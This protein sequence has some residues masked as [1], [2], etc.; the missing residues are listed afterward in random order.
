MSLFDFIQQNDGIR[1][2]S[3]SY[4]HLDVYKRQEINLAFNRINIKIPTTTNTKAILNVCLL[5]TS[6]NGRSQYCLSG[7]RLIF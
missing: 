7:F 2:T 6:A 4:T 1:F 5:Y 3:V